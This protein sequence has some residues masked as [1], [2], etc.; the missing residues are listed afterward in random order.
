LWFAK[1][2]SHHREHSHDQSFLLRLRFHGTRAGDAILMG[3]TVPQQ[4]CVS[5]PRIACLDLNFVEPA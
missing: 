4:A 5:L 2:R 1:S 3:N